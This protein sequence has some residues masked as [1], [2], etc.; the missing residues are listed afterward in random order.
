M[1]DNS[2]PVQH[3]I[4]RSPINRT[5]TADIERNKKSI[6]SHEFPECYAE[7]VE[8]NFNHQT[9]S[10]HIIKSHLL[11]RRGNLKG[12]PCGM[13]WHASSTCQQKSLQRHHG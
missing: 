4:L 7:G 6:L 10:D 2:A 3:T 13:P 8:Q 5:I 1:A 12:Q 9:Q 11:G